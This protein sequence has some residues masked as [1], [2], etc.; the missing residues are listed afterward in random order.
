MLDQFIA[1]PTKIGMIGMLAIAV[2]AFWKGWVIP[3][4]THTAVIA[5][6]TAQ[7]EA[8]LLDTVKD[9]N[10]FKDMLLKAADTADRAI[11]VAQ[12]SAGT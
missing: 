5:Q 3:G 1:D 9:K 6:I 7:Y 8:R 11:I 2:V 12:K 10:E 4:T